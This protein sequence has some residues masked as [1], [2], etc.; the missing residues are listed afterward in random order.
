MQAIALNVSP[1]ISFSL[2]QKFIFLFAIM[3]LLHII[4]TG[5]TAFFVFQ[6]ILEKEL[7]MIDFKT[8]ELKTQI[9]RYYEEKS[10]VYKLPELSSEINRSEDDSKVIKENVERNSRYEFSIK[11]IQGIV[12]Y[13]EDP[14]LIYNSETKDYSFKITR[15][16][17]FEKIFHLTLLSFQ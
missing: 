12:Q 14:K 16:I 8:A 6:K 13:K 4:F 17:R 5:I 2:K 9:E 10:D 1:K 11:T 7:T 3:L 15:E